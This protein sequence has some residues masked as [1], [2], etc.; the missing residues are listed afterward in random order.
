MA[1]ETEIVVARARVRSGGRVLLVRRAARDSMPG[2]WEL[3]GGKVD[4]G[5]PVRDALAREVEEETGLA[6]L[7]AR[8]GSRRWLIS[9]SGRWVRE[10]VYEA[11]AVGAVALS[12]E[13]DAY[14]WVDEPGSLPLTDAAALALA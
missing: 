1:A 13:H 9:P 6:L 7:G 10:L 2:R 12:D 8:L 14:A 11:S 5:E 4:G 3:P